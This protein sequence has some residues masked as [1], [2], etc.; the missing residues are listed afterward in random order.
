MKKILLL[1]LLLPLFAAAQYREGKINGLNAVIYSPAGNK[2]PLPTIVF[3][4]GIGE[5]GTN[6]SL[7]YR[8][9]P[10][11]FLKSGA[12]APPNMNIICVQPS[13]GW[14]PPATTAKILASV[15]STVNVSDMYLTGLSAGAASI[16]DFLS[17]TPDHGIKAIVVMSYKPMA[18]QR[19]WKE[20]PSTWGIS[21]DKDSDYGL[22]LKKM[23]AELNAIGRPSR[24]TSY[25]GGHS[26]WQTFY[27][28]AW[29]EGGYSVYE[30]MAAH[31]VPAVPEKPEPTKPE[32]SVKGKRIMLP[33]RT[34]PAPGDTLVIPEGVTSIKITNFHGTAANKI[35]I[36]Y[37]KDTAAFGRPSSVP[38]VAIEDATHFE[39]VNLHISAGPTH[40]GMC[41]ALGKGTE[42]YTV[43]NFKSR[44]G[45]NGIKAQWGSPAAATPQYNYPETI[46]SVIFSGIDVSET[47]TEGLYIGNTLAINSASQLKAARF[48]NL[49]IENVKVTNAYWDPVQI[50]M[51]ELVTLR[52]I[53]VNGF[54][55]E[56]KASQQAG[57]LIGGYVTFAQP[58]EN[59]TI[60]NGSG[61]GLTVFG[62]GKLHFKNLVIE[63]ADVGVYADDYTDGFLGLPAQEI[64]LENATIIGSKSLDIEV[65]NAK[66]TA[67][68]TTYIN[69]SADPAK[70]KDATGGTLTP[71]TPPVP[72]WPK[73]ATDKSGIIYILN[74]DN[75]WKIK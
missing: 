52:N 2:S 6:I 75:T 57:V 31:S 7:L 61:G 71:V 56:N 54:G 50:A 10:A 66:K 62:R 65:R 16:F 27:N 25:A 11:P 38:I 55:L 4:P 59:I 13:Y 70:F 5:D 64:I 45:T 67:K 39:V 14:I 28:P 48:K 15:R 74:K 53:D 69:V 8:N 58:A 34:A 24:F 44:Y 33:F 32:P 22:I 26:G 68:K 40:K 73:E 30:W 42:K 19:D 51:A 1:L 41:L 60:R 35:V 3:F 63:G 46:D 18:D 21:G 37:A 47:I 36:V 43:R 29:R 12:L 9:G 49:L 23:A 20:Y 17:K 72:E